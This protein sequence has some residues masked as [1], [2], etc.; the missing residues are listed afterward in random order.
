MGNIWRKHV[1][2]L[3]SRT[4]ESYNTLLVTEEIILKNMNFYTNIDIYLLHA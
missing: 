4:A 3:F 2:F 1:T